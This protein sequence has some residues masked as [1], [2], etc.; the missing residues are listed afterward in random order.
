I[1]KTKTRKIYAL[2][3]FLVLFYFVSAW[4]IAASTSIF[5]FKGNLGQSSSNA[6][7]Q[8]YPIEHLL[9]LNPTALRNIFLV[10]LVIGIVHWC[11]SMYNM[12]GKILSIL[13]ANAPD[14]DDF[15]HKKFQN[16][17]DE[18]SVATG[19]RKI[20]SIVLPVSALNAFSVADFRGRAVIGVTEG[21]LSRLNRAQLEAVVA[22]EAAHIVSNDALINTV[23]VSLFGIYGALLEKIQGSIMGGV[24]LRGNSRGRYSSGGRLGAYVVFMYLVIA[25]INGLGKLISSFISRTCEYRA[26]AVAVRLVR[27]PYSLAQSLHLISKKWRGSGLGYGYL[28]SIFIVNPEVSALDDQENLFSNLFSTHPPT[29]KR[30]SILLNMAHSDFDTLENETEFVKRPRGKA[31]TMSS[32]QATQSSRWLIHDQGVWK[33]PFPAAE[34]ITLGFFRND[35]FV[36]REGSGE[37]SFAHEH[38]EFFQTAKNSSAQGSTGLCPRCYQGLSK[39]HYESAPIELCNSCQGTLVETSKIPRILLRHERGFLD[40][41]ERKAKI[42]AETGQRPYKFKRVRMEDELQCPKCTRKMLRQLYTLVYPIEI[43]KCLSC[44]V[45]WFDREELDILQYL[46]ESS[47]KKRML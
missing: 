46:V 36:K 20:E 35:L 15:Y 26:D 10:A 22:H 47:E 3:I 19:G 45:V 14:K 30:M 8:A 13:R 31:I 17:I 1:E 9:L 37:T 43:D 42:V 32:N 4:I 6:F 38:A 41:V 40:E 5:L 18:V 21:L 29:T 28:E 23:A 24:S 33:G 25:I 7:V 27:D 39:I 44:G 16:I 11:N 34:L 2:F 12:S